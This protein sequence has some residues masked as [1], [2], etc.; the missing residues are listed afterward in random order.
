MGLVS[1]SLFVDALRLI[2]IVGFLFCSLTFT[3]YSFV[4][5]IAVLGEASR[6]SNVIDTCTS[7]PFSVTVC[8]GSE[9]VPT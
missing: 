2:S 7:V 9:Q 1:W 6:P 3:W 4:S 5:L 8:F